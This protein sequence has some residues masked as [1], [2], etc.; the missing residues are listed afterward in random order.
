MNIVYS[1]SDLYA[2]PTAISIYSLLQN[3]QNVDEINLFILESSI[4]KRNNEIITGI[5]CSFFRSVTYIDADEIFSTIA[6]KYKLELL[7]GAYSTYARVFINHFLPD[8]DKV[9]LIDS[10]TLVLGSLHELW[11]HN[12]DGAIIG[13]VPEAVVY[14]KKSFHEDPDI[15]YGSNYYYNMGVVLL[16]L[17]QWRALNIDNVVSM[18][19]VSGQKYKIADQSIINKYLADRISRLPLKFNFYTFFHGQPSSRLLNRLLNRKVFDDIEIETASASPVII[20]FVGNWFERPWYQRGKSIY[21]GIYS[22]YREKTAYGSKRM[23][24]A[25][26]NKRLFVLLLDEFIVLMQAVL[27][28]SFYLVLRY[29][30]MQVMKKFLKVSR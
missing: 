8:L 19:L 25:Q 15:V 26:N 3:N 22:R 11:N 18:A 21:K 10:D 30:Y 29:E 4:S 2:E 28:L 1:S 14:G 16:D 23:W 24:P 6:P 13:A 20:H 9:I 17:A 12:L 7:R 27:P 5:V